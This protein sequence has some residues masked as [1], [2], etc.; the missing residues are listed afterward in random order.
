MYEIQKVPRLTPEKHHSLVMFLQ[1]CYF[2]LNITFSQ[3]FSHLTIL[4]F[5]TII[6]KFKNKFLWD[7]SYWNPT[8]WSSLLLLLKNQLSYW[9]ILSIML[10]KTKPK[11][12]QLP[13]CWG[14]TPT[15]QNK[16]PDWLQTHITAVFSVFWNL[17]ASPK[18]VLPVSFASV[19]A[20]VI[21][22]ASS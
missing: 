2:L 21:F 1:S 10:K 5:T 8:V 11:P 13:L 12:N 6:S 16:K 9:N 19:P 15:K 18:F 7:I 22:S 17:S 3:H 20:A 14:R 4:V